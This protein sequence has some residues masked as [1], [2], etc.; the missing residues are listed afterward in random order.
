MNRLP[1]VSI[2]LPVYN[3]ERFV[4]ATLDSIVRQTFDNWELIISDNASTDRTAAICQEYAQRDPRIR[5][6]RNERNIGSTR[7]FNQ[8]VRLASAPYFKLT[9]ADD[10]CE[11]ELLARCVEVL[12]RRPAVALCYGRTVLIDPDGHLLRPFEDGLDLRATRAEE[13]FWLA[14]ERTR[15]VNVI[16]GVMRTDSLRR[17]GLLGPYIGSD[18]VLVAELA[19]HGQFYE[20]PQILFYRRLHPKAYSSLEVGAR[21]EF[22]DPGK[23]GKRSFFLWRHQVEYHRAVLRAPLSAREK[24]RLTLGL[25]RLGVTNRWELLGE[26]WEQLQR[27]RTELS[28]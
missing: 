25:L 20:L 22:V 26:L 19:L 5:Y 21:Q 1:R 12:D 14:L 24:L 15:L 16:Q 7:N 18:V 11:P 2:G 23:R 8:T 10:L 6:V 3:G 4:A 28:R 9:N 27:S 17:T 13:R